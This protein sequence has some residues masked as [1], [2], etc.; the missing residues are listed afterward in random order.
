[1]PHG[2]PDKARPAALGRSTYIIQR[3]FVLSTNFILT[4]AGGW[5]K[6]KNPETFVLRGRYEKNKKL[7]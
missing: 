3:F 4:T 1:M 2:W 6:M 7:P 5:C